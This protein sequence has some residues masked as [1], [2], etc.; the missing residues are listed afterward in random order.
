MAALAGKTIAV[1]SGTTTE[2]S[3]GTTLKNERVTA[4][5]VGVKD[6]AEGAAL[7]TAGKADA[8][9]ADRAIL[10]WLAARSGQGKLFVANNIFG[11]EPYALAL[12]LG[13]TQFRLLVDAQL[14]AIYR[15]G[16][17]NNTFKWNFGVDPSQTLSTMYL[18]NALPQ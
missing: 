1:R 6:H 7:L 16:E 9:F 5:I 14:S 17:I 15:S 8:Y 11:P 2:K 4:N 18:L 3:L 10:L 13:D 12:P